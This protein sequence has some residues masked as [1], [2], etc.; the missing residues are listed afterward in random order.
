MS[1]WFETHFRLH[2]RKKPVPR[3]DFLVDTLGCFHLFSKVCPQCA[4]IRLVPSIQH[5][6]RPGKLCLL[7]RQANEGVELCSVSRQSPTDRSRPA[8]HAED[9]SGELELN[10]Y[11]ELALSALKPS[12]YGDFGRLAACCGFFPV[13]FPSI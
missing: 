4:E 3:V 11:T 9:T 6:C 12:A 10:T 8:S 13:D 5:L 7:H 1:P 2:R